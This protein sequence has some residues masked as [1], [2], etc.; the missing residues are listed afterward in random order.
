MHARGNAVSDSIGR[1][2]TPTSMKRS[3]VIL[4]P[5]LLLAVACSRQGGPSKLEE[6]AAA[7]DFRL[8][9]AEGGEVALRD[10]RGEKAVLL[11]FSM[12]PG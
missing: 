10:F 6:G 2:P 7:P 3:L 1:R 5:L 9:S 8:P 4:L 11:Y 12:G